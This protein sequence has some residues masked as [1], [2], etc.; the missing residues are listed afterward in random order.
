MG[1]VFLIFLWKNIH[2]NRLQYDASWVW[3]KKWK[4]SHKISWVIF[5]AHKHSHCVENG[6]H[7]K[8]HFLLHL[9]LTIIILIRYVL[10]WKNS[11]FF[12]CW[13]VCDS[14]TYHHHH[15]SHTKPIE[16]KSR[17]W[18]REKI[19]KLKNTSKIMIS[20]NSYAFFQIFSLSTFPMLISSGNFPLSSSSL[21]FLV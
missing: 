10:K 5:I 19:R 16:I 8:V 14:T 1:K 3:K 12:V 2:E 17:S 21:Y 7:I 13:N 11:I 4:K 15:Y 9:F 18:A 20:S 6:E